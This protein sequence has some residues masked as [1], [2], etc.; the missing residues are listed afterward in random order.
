VAWYRVEGGDKLYLATDVAET[1][2]GYQVLE[3]SFPTFV[4]SNLLVLGAELVVPFSDSLS[5]YAN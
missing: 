4:G 1:A 2:M 5:S 3:E